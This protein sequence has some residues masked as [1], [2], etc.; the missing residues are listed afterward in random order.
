VVDLCFVAT[1]KGGQRSKLNEV[2]VRRWKDGK[3]VHER[4][5][6]AAAA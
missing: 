1:H 4:F 3:V 2:A 6:Y 5:Y